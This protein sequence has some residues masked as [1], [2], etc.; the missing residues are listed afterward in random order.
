MMNP[1]EKILVPIDDSE[2]GFQAAWM[3]FTIARAVGA[4]ITMI[5]IHR[6]ETAL[7][8]VV[9]IEAD[10]LIALPE[11]HFGDLL[12][13]IVGDPSYE[14]LHAAVD[15]SVIEIEES[16]FDPS[17]EILKYA[18]DKDISLIVMGSRVHSKIEN[19]VLGNVSSDVLQKAHCPVT[20]VH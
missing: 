15:H 12:K 16:S 20:I 8:E 13:K 4:S 11:D 5:H 17:D 9:V 2:P 7:R 1:I 3:A 10:D 19:L 14:A 18:D 6:R